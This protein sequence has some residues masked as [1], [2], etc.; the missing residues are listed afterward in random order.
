MSLSD[1]YK[2]RSREIA[3]E[4][5]RLAIERAQSSAKRIMES[6]QFKLSALAL[7]ENSMA[8]DA[9]QVQSMLF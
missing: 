8:V 2:K 9:P 4:R 1:F 6:D 3:S 7:P 5:E